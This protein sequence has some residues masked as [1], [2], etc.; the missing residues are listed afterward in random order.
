M[1][2]N[3]F[4]LDPSVYSEECLAFDLISAGKNIIDKLENIENVVSDCVVYDMFK[5]ISRSVELIY[6]SKDI[7]DQLISVKDENIIKNLSNSKAI[8]I[9]T[10]GYIDGLQ[11]GNGN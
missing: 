3:H 6:Y 10:H 5:N 1:N 9:I 8:S 7:E 4:F 2:K 11:S